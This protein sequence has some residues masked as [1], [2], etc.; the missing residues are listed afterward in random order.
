MKAHEYVL[1]ALFTIV[2]IL[3]FLLIRP[4]INILLTSIILSYIFFPIYKRIRNK[5]NSENISAIITVLLI[6]AITIT[7]LFFIADVLIKES[8]S[9]YKGG[10]IQTI[11]DSFSAVTNNP[12]LSF[13][14]DEII[15]VT[16][17]YLTKLISSL[18]IKIPSML[19]DVF[20]LI[21]VT[22]F[23]FKD[24]EHIIKRLETL[25]LKTV[26][27]KELIEQFKSITQS[28]VYSWF[29]TAILQGILGFIGFLIFGISNPVFWGIVMTILAL[30]PAGTVFIWL[31]AAIWL[32][33][34]GS[35]VQGVGLLLYGMLIISLADNLF[36][37]Y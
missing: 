23:L 4:F 7:P 24:G 27:R 20:V 25:P 3:S 36:R 1:I 9:L 14:L 5:T 33:A 31:P 18:I 28:T 26:H 29:L 11:M 15:K 12:E 10:Q 2:L 16:S 35:L 32:I 22:F 8:I 17:N 34:T 19:L 13:Y 21:F 30:L 37:E 6:I